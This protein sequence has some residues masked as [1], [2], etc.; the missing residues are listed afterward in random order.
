MNAPLHLFDAY[1]VELEYMLVDRETLVVKPVCDRVLAAEAGRPVAELSRGTIGWSIELAAHVLELE[2]N[3]LT[4]R[5]DADKAQD[6]TK[7]LRRVDELAAEHGARVLPTAMH[8]L[9][10]PARDTTVWRDDPIYAAFDRIFGCAGHGWSNLQSCHLNLPFHGDDEFHRLHAAIRSVLPLLPGLAASSPLAEGR[11]TGMLDTRLQVYRENQRKLGSIIGK[12]IPEA[13]TSAHEYDEQILRPMYREIAPL[14]PEGLLQHEWLNFR[15]AAAHFDRGTIQI[16][17]LDA[18]ETP[19]ADLAIVRLVAETVRALAEERWVPL[20]ELD[21]LSTN[22]L[23]D[24][25]DKTITRAEHAVVMSEPL[26]RALGYHGHQ[27]TVQELWT[28]LAES[29]L[30]EQLPPQG[31]KGALETI[32]NRG[33]LATRILEAVGSQPTERRIIEVYGQLAD[34]ALEGQLFVA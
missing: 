28:H 6:F 11:I 13:V 22:M 12:V 14:D 9:M 10:D 8:P 3:V 23:A 4:T 34:C 29:L 18:Q 27:A 15:G 2:T 33:T 19:R 24:L 17:L 5:L 25:L 1:G 32:L 26:L 20:H 16:R 21:R 7:D 31:L 30:L